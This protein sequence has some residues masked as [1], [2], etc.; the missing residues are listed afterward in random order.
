MMNRFALKRSPLI[1]TAVLWRL[2]TFSG[3]AQTALTAPPKPSPQVSTSKTNKTT[4]TKL[5][6]SDIIKLFNAKLKEPLIERMVRKENRIYDLQAADLIALKEAGASD[7]FIEVML[8]PTKAYVPVGPAD[9]PPPVPTE[10]Q[11]ATP[12]ATRNGIVATVGSALSTRKEAAVNAA[13]VATITPTTATER[14]TSAS[15]PTDVG[16]YV[17]KDGVWTELR[18]EIVNWKTGGTIKSLASAGVVKKD[19]NGNID[20]PASKNTL[21]APLDVLIVT[22]EGLAPEEYQ[23]LRLRVSKDYREFRSVTGGIL[24]QRS[25]AMRDLVPFE[26]KKLASHTFVVIVPQNIGAGEYGFLP[27]GAGGSSTT[28]AVSAQ[29]G[30]IYTFHIVE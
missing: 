24:N 22:P 3:H 10:G 7:A 29:S 30:K 4:Q 15:I 27:P 5:T 11:T 26:A 20:G 14:A 25:G 13:N 17:K 12:S 28:A 8:D 16:V 18:P 6:V 2:S 21:K 1:V 9:P 23:F 19:L